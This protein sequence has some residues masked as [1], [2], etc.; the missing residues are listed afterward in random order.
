MLLI[1]GG[2]VEWHDMMGRGRRA[3]STPATVTMRTMGRGSV[4]VVLETN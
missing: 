2:V 1:V 4:P 3:H